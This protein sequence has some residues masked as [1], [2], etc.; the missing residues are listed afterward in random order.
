[1]QVSAHAQHRDACQQF[2]AYFQ[3]QLLEKHAPHL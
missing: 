1:M 2:D 3:H